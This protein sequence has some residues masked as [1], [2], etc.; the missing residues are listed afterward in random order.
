MYA[1]IRS[2]LRY[3][4]PD[5][6]AYNCDPFQNIPP[7]AADS[8]RAAA[9][10]L[11]LNLDLFFVKV[12]D[13]MFIVPKHPHLANI[14][15]DVQY[16]EVLPD[17]SWLFRLGAPA[18]WKE[19]EDSEAYMGFTPGIKSYVNGNLV[20]E[21][22]AKTA[23]TGR[24]PFAVV[25][26]PRVGLT[27]IRSGEPEYEE[28]AKQQDLEGLVAGMANW[29]GDARAVAV[30]GFVQVVRGAATAGEGGEAA[31]ATNGDARAN[32]G[33]SRF[34]PLNTEAT[35]VGVVDGIP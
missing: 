20:G 19:D 7:N 24:T 13:F 32:A 34:Q 29:D 10:P 22:K 12:S 14:Q 3:Y 35:N 4:N 21:A 16:H 5:L 8:L 23:L 28:V 2:D 30:N 1:M 11:F 6:A 15:L 26:V 27:E 33:L 9:E 17:P 18:K 31:P 25:R